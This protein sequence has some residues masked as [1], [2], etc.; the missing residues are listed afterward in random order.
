M[1]TKIKTIAKK[2]SQILYISYL[3]RRPY[4]CYSLQM[5]H[6]QFYLCW[7]NG[8]FFVDYEYFVSIFLMSKRIKF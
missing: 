6:S 2:A 4:G 8:S 3:E 5:Q 7:Q 1:E